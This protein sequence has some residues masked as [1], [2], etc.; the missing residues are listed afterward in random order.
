VSNQNYSNNPEPMP[1]AGEW[2]EHVKSVAYDTADASDHDRET[3]KRAVEVSVV[4]AYH[5]NADALLAELEGDEDATP[6]IVAAIRERRRKLAEGRAALGFV[7]NADD[8]GL[9]A[10]PL[11][12]DVPAISA[13]LDAAIEAAVNPP[14]PPF[15]D[16]DLRDRFVKRRGSDVRYS[17]KDWF[18]WDGQMWHRDETGAIYREVGAFTNQIADTEFRAGNVDGAKRIA[19]EATINKIE[20]M[21]QTAQTINVPA[22]VWDTEPMQLNTPGGI[23][24]LTTGKLR[25]ATRADYVSKCAFC[26]PLDHDS[27]LTA[28]PY[29][30]CPE[31]GKFLEWATQRDVEMQ[32][33]LQRMFGYIL[34]ADYS[35]QVL[36]FFFGNGHNGKSTLIDVMQGILCAGNY[37]AVA[38]RRIFAARKWEAH[39]TELAHLKGTRLAAA[40]EGR[41]GQ[42]WDDALIKGLTGGSPIGAR[43]IGK[44]LTEFAPTFKLVFASNHKPSLASVDVGMRRRVHMVNFPVVLPKESVDTRLG[45]KLK[46]EYPAI[47]RWAITGCLAWRT[48][49]LM[50]PEAV[51]KAS[52]EFLDNQDVRGRWIEECCEV[53][54]GFETESTP[55]WQNWEQWADARREEKTTNTA[56]IEALKNKG[57]E[58]HKDSRTRRGCFRGI[59]LRGGV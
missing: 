26:A 48:G 17:G 46:K 20:R 14:P 57:F 44:D 6:E 52:E 23:V 19:S 54:P 51:T 29:R 31:F 8:L 13:T 24:D 59:R 27:G 55:L 25:P 10:P 1:D 32:R 34:T 45:E 33:Y 56:F 53:G 43:L 58:H 30:D 7:P 9:I 47:L 49:G 35:E 3:V 40:Q 2:A 5:K 21:A 39:S 12:L 18:I 16:A 37:A 11:S 36:F 22:N 41:E 15:S 42:M 4:L 28:D 38:D 50:P